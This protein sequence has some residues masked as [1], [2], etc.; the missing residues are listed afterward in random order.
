MAKRAPRHPQP[1]V[2]MWWPDQPAATA[3]DVSGDKRGDNAAAEPRSA[4][5]LGWQGVGHTSCRPAWVRVGANGH[6]AAGEHG[7]HRSR[8]CR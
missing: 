5:V 6:S 7:V 1:V 8:P 2:P 3:L 4:E